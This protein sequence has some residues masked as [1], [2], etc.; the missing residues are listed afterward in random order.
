METII[1]QLPMVV[2]KDGRREPFSSDKIL[3]GL[4]AACQKRPIA[5]AQL[6]HMVDIVKNWVL[7]VGDKEVSSQLIGQFVIREIKTLDEVA[8]I[9]FASVYK[10]F[11][12]VNEFVADISPEEASQKEA[13]RLEQETA[14]NRTPERPH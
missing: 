13:L 5:F 3:H 4:K 9:R 7:D 2:K 1:Q 14:K 11:K 8:Y 10:T 6:E 12:D